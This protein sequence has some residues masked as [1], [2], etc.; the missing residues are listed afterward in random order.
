MI[1]YCALLFALIIVS[2]G[3][4]GLV[5][6]DAFMIALHFFQTGHRI[7]LAGAMRALIGVVFLLAAPD[8]RWPRAMRV[9]GAG[10]ILLGLLTPVSNHPIPS[11]AWGWW[12]PNFV[13][14]WALS[15]MAL[16]LFVIAAV[17][18]PRALED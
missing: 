12:S 14:P 18:P 8:S 15:S 4:L 9:V 3:L 2:L 7:Y 13:R 1:R 16:G 5:A 11:V 10:V 6:P 17:V